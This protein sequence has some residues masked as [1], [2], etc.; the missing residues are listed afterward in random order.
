MKTYILRDANVARRFL[1]QGLWGQRV[2]PPTAATVR[3]ALEWALEAS[4]AGQIL[5][6]PGFLA[7]LGHVAFGLDWE[8]RGGRNQVSVPGLPINLL[9]TYE[10]HV[11]GK[12]YAD[13]TFGRASEA[14]RRYHGRGQAKALAFF[15]NQFQARSDFDGAQMSPSVIKALLEPPPEEVLNQGWE[16]LQQDGIQAPLTELY[17]SLITASRR[18]AEVLGPEDIDELES[19]DVLAEEGERLAKRQVRQAAVRL[20]TAL[21]RTRVRRL[22]QRMEVPT[23]ILD[24]DTYPVGGFTS[25]SNRG[26]IES[27]LHSQ[28]AYMEKDDRP[29]MFDIKFLRDEL[30]YYSR[31]ENQFLRRRRTFVFVMQPDLSH[32]RFKDS[33]L[34]YQRGVLMLALIFMAVRKLSEWLS[35]DAL[36]FRILFV[37]EKDEEPLK[38]E[39]ELLQ[40]LFREQIA[41]GTVFLERVEAEQVESLCR[42]W[43][44]RS[45]VHCLILGENPPALEPADTVVTRLK[46]AGPRPAL[47]D[48]VEEPVLVEAED[49]MD[50]WSQALEKVLQRWV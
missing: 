6:P 39:R 40:S 29:D 47:G 9:R 26:S 12:I 20:E 37:V 32:T 41:S 28:L 13:W 36:Y 8:M 44:R 16:S 43:A 7:D 24:E 50:S 31:D 49:A 34:T 42:N 4:S 48:G 38:A 23:R 35:T 46:I 22:A 33:E 45:M 18:T 30:L 21:P 15:L 11:L 2:L 19:G 5:P 1:L 27:L 10:D 3:P 14:M 17:E 25:I